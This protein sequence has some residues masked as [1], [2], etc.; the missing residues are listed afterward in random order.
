MSK[1]ETPMT[2]RYWRQVRG[3]LLLDYLVVRQRPGVG[4]RGIDAITIGE[5]DHRIVPPAERKK[6]HLDGHDIVIV[7]AKASRLGINPLGQAFFSRE[8]VT[9]CWAPKCIRTVALRRLDDG[10]LC[11]IAERFGIEIVVNNTYESRSNAGALARTSAA[12]RQEETL[13]NRTVG[14]NGA[15]GRI[16]QF[17]QS[18][19]ITTVSSKASGGY[20]NVNI[21]NPLSPGGSIPPTHARFVGYASQHA[22]YQRSPLCPGTIAW[23]GSSLAMRSFARNAA[24]RR[25]CRTVSLSLIIPSGQAAQTRPR[26]SRWVRSGVRTPVLP[27]ENVAFSAVRAGSIDGFSATWVSTLDW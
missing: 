24:G 2:R 25:R 16:E 4:P 18:I 8:L 21:N 23:Q 19:G 14:D 26:K 7:Q 11:P 10:V 3:T 17:G 12:G 27:D 22:K 13:E 9:A 5:G 15:R 20:T 1:R 6:F